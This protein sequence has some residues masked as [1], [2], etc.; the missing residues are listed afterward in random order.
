MDKCPLCLS[1][2]RLGGVRKETILDPND[3][4][5]IIKNEYRQQYCDCKSN[6]DYEYNPCP[7]YMVVLGEKLME[8]ER[9]PIVSGIKGFAEKVVLEQFSGDEAMVLATKL[10]DKATQEGANG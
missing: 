3:S 10:A 1:K 6:P 9:I 5:I 7:N 2:L 4:A 8:T